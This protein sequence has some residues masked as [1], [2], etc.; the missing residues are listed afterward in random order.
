MLGSLQA[1]DAIVVSELSRLRPQH[2]RVYGD[3]LGGRTKADQHLFGKGG[4]ALR[5]E[6]P[7][8]NH[9]DGLF[10]GCGGAWAGVENSA[11]KR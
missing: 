9:R 6:H 7:E 5:P 10:D 11:P 4:L 3:P 1:K 8:Q 2:G